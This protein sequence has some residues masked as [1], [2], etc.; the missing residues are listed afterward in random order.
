MASAT[1][2]KRPPHPGTAQMR[3]IAPSWQDRKRRELPSS[4]GP[5]LWRSGQEVAHRSSRNDD[6]Q[7]VVH[8]SPSNP[9]QAGA[10]PQGIMAWRGIFECPQL[11]LGLLPGQEPRALFLPGVR[12][13]VDLV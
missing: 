8:L 6:I 7:R 4:P 3:T 5:L 11:R 1:R 10:A 13:V 2:L 12:V 9:R